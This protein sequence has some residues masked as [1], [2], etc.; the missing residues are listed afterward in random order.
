V[1]RRQALDSALGGLKPATATSTYASVE[2]AYAAAVKGFV[3]GRPNSVL[4]I[5]DGPNDDASISSRQLLASVRAGA[6][7]GRPVRVDVITI[8]ENSDSNTLRQ[9]ADQTGGTLLA[10]PS[11][12]GPEL[13]AAIGKLL[14]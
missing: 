9:L 4:L 1:P 2:A 8:G 13:G 14:A 11:S 10:V 7:D 5:T 6:V 3:P 12:N